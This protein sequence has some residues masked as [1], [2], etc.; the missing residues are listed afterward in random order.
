MATASAIEIIVEFNP[1]ML[2]MIHDTQGRPV[3]EKEF[4]N[5]PQRRCPIT[6]DS[7]AFE[8]LLYKSAYLQQK[9]IG[10]KVFN[11]QAWMILNNRIRAFVREI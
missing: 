8:I 7:L 1:L 5:A 10:N 3:V 6:I 2:F 9:S 4:S 11:Q